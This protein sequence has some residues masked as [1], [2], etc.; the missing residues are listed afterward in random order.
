MNN[1]CSVFVDANIAS[2]DLASILEKSLDGEAEGMYVENRYLDIGVVESD[3]YCRRKISKNA[4]DSFIYFPFKLEV[5]FKNNI[6]IDNCVM[7]INQIIRALMTDHGYT[8]VAACDYEHL[9]I[10]SS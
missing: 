6:P 8:V 3:D 2:K 10:D 7:Q 4:M 9:L 1:Y 5:E